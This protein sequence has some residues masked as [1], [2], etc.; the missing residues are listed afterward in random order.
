M[1]IMEVTDNY[2]AVSGRIAETARRCG[3]NPADIRLVVVTKGHPVETIER[4]IE[5]GAQ[6]LGEN[7]IEEA[8][9]KIA[10]LAGRAGLQWHM[11]GHVQ[12]RK[13]RQVCLLF[14]Y[15][16]S[17][18]GIKLA[19]RI[20]RCEAESGVKLP[21]LLECNVSGEETKFGFPAWQED[22]WWELIPV[23]EKMASFSN[24]D[25][26]GL[27]T[28]APYFPEAEM[29]RPYFQRLRRL[30]A[31]LTSRIPKV[32]WVELSMGMSADYEVA[33]EEGATIV[34]IGT[35]ILGSRPVQEEKQG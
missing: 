19:E 26:R 34:R 30:L 25:V 11:I 6:H 21:V 2:Y 10:S 16:H 20:D 3:R 28:M 9:P 29:A 5:A 23:L 32:N 15:L 17:L 7:Y 13:A 18:D 31:Y 1:S 4:V 33:V 8:E 12:S 27:M 24:L 22:R 14:N 35:A